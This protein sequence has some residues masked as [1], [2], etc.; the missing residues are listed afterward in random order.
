MA[1]RSVLQVD[2]NDAAFR[3][4]AKLHEK[5][6]E[7]VKQAPKEWREQ[8]EE[9]EEAAA[10]M[11][12][13][14]EKLVER[15]KLGKEWEEA[16]KRADWITASTVERFKMLAHQGA[17][18]ASSI[19][20]ATHMLLRWTGITSL[21]S[22]GLGA[23]AVF[24]I[25]NLALSAAGQRR[26]ALGI[27]ARIGEPQAFAAN[28]SRLIDPEGFLS[29]VA[30]AK[31]DIQ[32]R[33]GLLAAG[34]T[35]GQISG[36]TGETAT[37][38]LRNL[39]RLADKWDPRLFAQ[40]IEAF[41]LGGVVSPEDLMRLRSTKPE[42]RE[43]LFRQY[44]EDAA[45]FRLPDDLARRWQEFT[46]QLTRAGQSI[47][48]TLIKGLV[49]LAHPFEKLS[50]AAE[51]VIVAFMKSDTL[52]HWI[53]LVSDGLERF[54][55][56]VGRP[57]F[58]EKVRSFVDGLG[59]ITTAIGSAVAWFAHPAAT[60]ANASERE[61]QR[62]RARAILGGLGFGGY[63][64]TNNFG[65]LKVPG[66]ATEFQ[67]FPTPEA[68]VSAMAAQIRRYELRDHLDTVE[69]I[70]SK[71]A[72]P[73][74]NN[75]PAYIKDVAQRM[76]IVPTQTLN[77]NDRSELAR[78]LAAMIAHENRAGSEKYKDAK[79]IIDILNKTGDNVNLSV[80]GLKQ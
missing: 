45:R 26:G 42:E 80:N 62:Q 68:G 22:L 57:E 64:G 33:T 39:T 58:D 48:Q 54:S 1:V 60:T 30:R 59:T 79:V 47:E 74:E 37:A 35:Q 16:A 61:T 21:F 63:G 12:A 51:K 10:S 14:V 24:G 25:D 41:R 43:R 4:F 65:N 40:Y 76:G 34:L 19:T 53:D 27:G 17:K 5:Y 11:E 44:G 29:G 66:S 75:T 73:S 9:M 55:R 31:M 2:V 13:M 15:N 23:S 67:S 36:S 46:T 71:Y 20:S 7:A 38:L 28:F 6:M 50:Q 70:I 78:L 52:K 56:Y 77:P 69:K 8:V 72:P 3:E 32:Q 49:P 18:F